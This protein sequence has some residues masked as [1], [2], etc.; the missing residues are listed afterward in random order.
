MKVSIVGAG[1]VGRVLGLLAKR[2][3]H[4]IGD[5]VCRSALSARSA[6]KFIGGG[7]T[8]YR[9]QPSTVDADLI[10]ICVADDRISEIAGTL[11]GL[12]GR[13]PGPGSR[14][15]RVALHVSGAVSSE[16]LAPLRGIGISIGSCHP[17]QT[18]ETPAR[19]L[20]AVPRS[21]FRLEGDRVA[22]RA[23]RKFVR[24][25][26]GRQIVLPDELKGLYHA[27]AV[28]ASGG[29]V[30]LL[31]VCSE[32][33]CACGLTEPE[34][35]GALLPLVQGT[36]DNVRHAGLV[37]AL[38]GPVRRGDLG[39]L[40]KN[41]TAIALDKPERLDLYRMLA[42]ASLDLAKRQGMSGSRIKAMRRI[43]RR[44]I[45]LPRS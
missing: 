40:E 42:D 2:A 4:E 5:V 35:I 11:A 7:V 32:L 43:I 6:R 33:L 31:S 21:C 27:S 30:A 37:S 39:T 19:A 24:E 28:M 1:R 13:L 14:K 26:G 12:G 9:L 17:L 36:I 22:L 23:A 3:G 44:S 25:I 16:A 10:L 38:T 18:F 8:R 41:L 34:S 29:L 45:G 20:A 15:S